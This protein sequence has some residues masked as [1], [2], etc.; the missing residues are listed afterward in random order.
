M[1]PMSLS[2]LQLVDPV[3]SRLVRQDR[4]GG[5]I[6]D[7]ICARMDVSKNAGLYP[8]WSREDFSR[9]SDDD[10]E[11]A[12]ADRAETPEIDFGYTTRPYV[13]RNFRRKVTISPEERE[14]AH[15]ALRFEASK[16]NGLRDYMSLIRER[17]LARKLRLV[18]NGGAL[19][20]GAAI[21]IKWDQSTATIEKDIQGARV[22]VNNATGQHVDTA[23]IPWKV[24]YA[25]ALHP[26][27]REIMKYTVD[28]SKILEL[29]DRILPKQLHGVT[30]LVPQVQANFARKGAA[31]AFQQVWGDHVRFVK[32][33]QDNA[34]GEVST[35]YALRGN[36]RSTGTT[37][38][39][40]EPEFALV[41]RWATPDPPV[42]HIRMWEKVE[43]HVTAAD[44]A[45]EL[46][47]AL[48]P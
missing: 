25:M 38:A 26:S 32:R 1:P 47:S 29:G 18:A 33:G 7:Q 19:T 30:L 22:A 48:T 45:Y 36:V 16:V 8:V 41:D 13:L 37:A 42:D 2:E 46:S 24:A 3:L 44:V 6:Y 34:W 31:A 14:Q 10:A 11:G 40:R 4:P 12:V 9:I 39:G 28:G 15:D 17:R 27:I 20:S 23:I 5:F 43:E 35:V 21:G